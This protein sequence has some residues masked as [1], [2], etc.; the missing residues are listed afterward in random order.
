MPH[1]VDGQC[2]ILR[3]TVYPG[4]TEK[5]DE[6]VRAVGPGRHV[7]FCPERVAEGH[8]MRGTRRAAADRLGLRRRGDRDGDRSVRPDRAVDHSDA[9]RWRPS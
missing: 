2:L 1:L 3:S 5:V 7:A 6:L 4:T 9:R 8:A